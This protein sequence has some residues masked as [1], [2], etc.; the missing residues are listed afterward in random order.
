MPAPGAFDWS[1]YYPL[2][3]RV[4]AERMRTSNRALEHFA[5]HAFMCNEVLAA[6]FHTRISR[7]KP[8]PP[9]AG[10]TEA[11]SAK[12]ENQSVAANNGT[13]LTTFTDWPFRLAH[14]AAQRASQYPLITAGEVAAT[15]T[16]SFLYQ[17]GVLR[18]WDSLAKAGRIPSKEFNTPEGMAAARALRMALLGESL[19]YLGGMD[20]QLGNTFSVVLEDERVARTVTTRSPEQVG[21]I[22]AAV[23]V[24]RLWVQAALTRGRT[25]RP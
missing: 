4:H 3:A 8:I 5:R 10:L 24:S 6:Y 13:V 19:R 21:R 12:G 18:Y 2:R 9:Q 25:V 20:A 7:P 11:A 15:Y 23:L 1:I 17:C 16:A 14:G 22:G